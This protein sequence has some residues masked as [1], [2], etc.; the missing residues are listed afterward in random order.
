[1]N[2]II[3]YVSSLAPWIYGLCGLIALYYLFRVRTLRLE[4]RQAIF[5]LEREQ[6]ARVLALIMAR[7]ALIVFIMAATYTVSN[8][9]GRAVEI[10]QRLSQAGRAPAAEPAETE[11]PPPPTP[12]RPPVAAVDAA[13]QI[14]LRSVPICDNDSAAILSPGVG[15]EIADLVAVTGTATNENF[16]NYRIEIAPGAEP[17]EEDFTLL[18]IGRSQV[19]S[20]RLQEFDASLYIT[21]LY[22]IRLQVLDN[23]GI[24]VGSCQVTV[25][26][27][28]S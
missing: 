13:G 5:S 10:E 23:N 18:G 25:R 22:T 6:A 2:L 28:A 19:R 20:G 4:R 14:D 7:V 24:N 9:L 1:M 15:Q 3:E 8:V 21:G 26:V 27:V 11:D 17:G 12:P 16:A